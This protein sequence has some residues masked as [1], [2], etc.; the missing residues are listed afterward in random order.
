M[1]GTCSGMTVFL[2]L[3]QGK[4]CVQTKDVKSD[5]SVFFFNESEDVV[6]KKE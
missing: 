6:I 1:V 4:K 3:V 2:N 5:V